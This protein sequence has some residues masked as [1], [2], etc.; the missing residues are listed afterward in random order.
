MQSHI[1]MS[2]S[3]QIENFDP[4]EAHWLESKNFQGL[5]SHAIIT[6]PKPIWVFFLTIFLIHLFF[7][8]WSAL[9]IY[10]RR[11]NQ[12]LSCANFWA[13]A[14]PAPHRF[15]KNNYLCKF[16]LLTQTLNIPAQEHVSLFFWFKSRRV[17]PDLLFWVVSQLQDNLI[18][19]HPKNLSKLCLNCKLCS[20]SSGSSVQQI[21]VVA[22]RL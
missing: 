10:Q 5:F 15:F 14:I 9:D 17:C 12:D 21:K 19:F 7:S 18:I 4:E 16:L 20:F 2:P 13:C 1:A 3:T 8:A 6:I 22:T 11:K